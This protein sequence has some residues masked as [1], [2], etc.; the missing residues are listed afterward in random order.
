L[1][2]GLISIQGT[3][4]GLVRLSTVVGK[5]NLPAST[6]GILTLG[7]EDDDFSDN[8]Y[9]S[10]DDG[11]AGQ[12]SDLNDGING[13]A[14]IEL[15]IHHQPG[16]LPAF[17]AVYGMCQQIDPLHETCRVDRPY[18]NDSNGE[19]FP[20]IQFRPGDTFVVTAGGCVQTGG[21]GKTWKRY[22][23]PSGPN[24]DHLYHGLINISTVTS[25]MVRLSSIVGAPLSISTNEALILGYEDDDYPDNGYWSHDDGTGNQ[26]Q[27]VGPAFVQ[28][29][30]THAAP[31][32]TVDGIEIV[33]AVQTVND[34]VSV[35]ADKMTWARVY[36]SSPQPL[37]GAVT[38]ALTVFTAAIPSGQALVPA[39]P[40]VLTP[41]TALQTRRE[42]WTGSLDFLLPT[43]TVGP[44]YAGFDVSAT[45]VAGGR[46]LSCN[47][48]DS[49]RVMNFNVSTPV[50][51]K[52]V[53]LAYTDA[54]S[55]VQAPRTVDY[56]LLQSWLTRAYPTASVQATTDL[57]TS[58]NAV[59]FICNA[60]N[61]Q[62][63]ALRGLDV[64]MNNV[65]SRTH[66]LALVSNVG[67]YMRGCASGIPATPDP[68]TVA[69]SPTGNPAGPGPVPVN[70]TG[71]TDASWGD[72][73]GGHELTHTYGRAHP[74]F[75]NGNS[76]DDLAFPYPNGQ[77]SDNA[78]TNTGL[79]VGDVIQ[80]VP[81]RVL[82][83]EAI[84]DI[85]TYCNQPQWLSPYTYEAVRL[86]LKAEDGTAGSMGSGTPS[87]GSPR[88]RSEAEAAY[89]HVV[90]SLNIT[91]RTAVIRYVNPVAHAIEQASATER[92]AELRAT[93]R[94]GRTVGLFPVQ[95]RL[96]TDI[97]PGEDKTALVDATVPLTPELASV[98]LVLEQKVVA[99]FHASHSKP[100]PP[101]GLKLA[102]LASSVGTNAVYAY[103]LKWLPSKTAVPTDRIVYSVQ[104][105]DDGQVW[106]AIAVG[107]KDAS[108]RLSAE[109]GRHRFIR[110]IA[111]NGFVDSD[112]ASIAATP[113][114]RLT[115]R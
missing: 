8:G 60:A 61:A 76:K 66:Y 103:A 93:G 49:A 5:T 101:K 37:E 42:A 63:A 3:T 87:A 107:L 62:L 32:V 58:N 21:S 39:A 53:G 20:A 6:G 72:W 104:W 82:P 89:V 65:D 71:D 19:G 55:N 7:Y 11:T 2:H 112:P 73:Y 80:A 106:Q 59:G 12:C 92:A 34:S 30:I 85:M 75:C 74:G 51:L 15:T 43:G 47:G 67:F 105:S 86:R 29:D 9:W 36:L 27:G 69:S 46:A 68:T 17:R 98:Q 84:F 52:I 95:I 79:D 10:H 108:L 56:N 38:S 35:I 41:G 54:A 44:G 78:G 115:A 113:G 109:Q 102:K 40:V 28:V 81:L 13:T 18:V 94:D 99:T 14:H 45:R 24:S 48:C 90:A 114:G 100:T 70:V 50:R 110:V 88:S 57:V 64:L 31:D 33:Q 22:V 97:P 23:D 111:T 91:K 25:G 4:A 26:C 96:D 1:Y 16:L 83:G 77:I